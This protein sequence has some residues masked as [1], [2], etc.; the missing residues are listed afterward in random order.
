MH[1]GAMP[2][3]VTRFEGI[4]EDSLEKMMKKAA[5]RMDNAPF[6]DPTTSYLVN[7]FGL[8]DPGPSSPENVRHELLQNLQNTTCEQVNGK[9]VIALVNKGR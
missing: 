8:L 7:A 9:S 6:A 2:R 5:R 3:A 1:R 4:M